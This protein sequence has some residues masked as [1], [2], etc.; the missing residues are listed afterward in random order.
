[1]M[2]I[3]FQLPELTSIKE[4][5]RLVF[6]IKEKLQKRFRVSAAEVDLQDSLSYTQIGAA[7]VS[8]SKKLGEAV[9]QKALAFIEDTVPARLQDVQ[10]YSEQF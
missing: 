2:Q 4:K 8:N 1:M 6:S 3:I 10:I 7:Y 5:R 9:L